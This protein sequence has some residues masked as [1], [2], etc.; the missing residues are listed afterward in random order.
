MRL[1]TMGCVTLRSVR[2]WAASRRARHPAAC[3]G[4]NFTS[5]RQPSFFL[6]RPG[7]PFVRSP[8]A[9]EA[10]NPRQNPSSDMPGAC[11]ES[12]VRLRAQGTPPAAHLCPIRSYTGRSLSFRAAARL[13]LGLTL[14]LGQG[15]G[16]HTYPA[17]S[18]GEGGGGVLR[19]EG[20]MC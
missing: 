14:G 19:A 1:D 8:R 17:G 4:L 5:R 11:Q 9:I 7:F 15:N 16:N 10:W 20:E 12:H 2:A 6:D 3:Q 18:E 13:G